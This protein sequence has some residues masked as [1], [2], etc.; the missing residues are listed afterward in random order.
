MDVADLRQKQVAD[1]VTD[2]RHAQQPS[3][4]RIGL[5]HAPDALRHNRY[6][7]VQPGNEVQILAQLETKHLR[8][9]DR[10]EKLKPPHAEEVGVLVGDASLVEH[11]M[12]AVLEA[13]A[14][15]DQ[16]GPVA[17]PLPLLPY[18]RRRN[19]SLGQKADTLQLS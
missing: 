2:T 17:Q 6:L 1:D 4:T 3:G 19:V 8:Q 13:G 16:G 18:L 7:S 10:L 5:Q 12:D 11:R 14:D 15:P 9:L